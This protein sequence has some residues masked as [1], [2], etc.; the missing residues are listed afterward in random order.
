MEGSMQETLFI[1]TT[2]LHVL[3]TFLDVPSKSSF[4]ITSSCALPLG[5]QYIIRCLL[6]SGMVFSCSP[7][8]L[9]QHLTCQLKV[10]LSNECWHPLLRLYP[11]RPHW[12]QFYKTLLLQWNNTFIRLAL[13]TEAAT[14]KV[15]QF[16]MPLESVQN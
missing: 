3:S 15:S 8:H 10:L 6:L 12:C 5:H 7:S 14:K 1:F 11:E 9:I 2:F 4:C 13:I 16:I